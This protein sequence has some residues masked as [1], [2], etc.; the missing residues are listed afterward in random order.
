MMSVGQRVAKINSFCLFGH[1]SRAIRRCLF[2][3]YAQPLFTW[4]PPLFSLFTAKQQTDF[5]HFYLVSLKRTLHCLGWT[6]EFFSYAANELS[7]IDHCTAYLVKISTAPPELS[8]WQSI[9]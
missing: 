7:L 8:R 2:V 1:K 3:T 9:A 4:L 6:D 5:E